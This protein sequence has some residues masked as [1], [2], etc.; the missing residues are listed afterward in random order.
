[1]KLPVLLGTLLLT[2]IPVVCSANIIRTCDN[3]SDTIQYRTTQK[4]A[5][6]GIYHCSILKKVDALENEEYFFRM[7]IMF[8]KPMTSSI[9]YLVEPVIDMDID[10]KKFKIRKVTDGSQPRT[11]ENSLGADICY[12]RLTADCVDALKTANKVVVTAKVPEKP[13]YV[14]EIN[15]SNIAEAKNIID[16]AHFKDYTKDLDPLT[17]SYMEKSAK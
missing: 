16:N 13:P 10:D 9:K 2:I 17:P 6:A 14:M 15:A 3:Q 11:F 5:G 4:V 8:A 1:M 7:T 12:Y